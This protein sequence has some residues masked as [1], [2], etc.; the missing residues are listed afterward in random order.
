VAKAL[1]PFCKFR[2][3][4][5]AFIEVHLPSRAEFPRFQQFFKASPDLLATDLKTGIVDT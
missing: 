2:E 1:H 3:R 5:R 4:H